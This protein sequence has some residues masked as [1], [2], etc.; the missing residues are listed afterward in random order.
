M[1]NESEGEKEDREEKKLYPSTI[2]KSIQVIL[3]PK[4]FKQG[5]FTG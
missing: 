5:L 2:L 4:G 1:S 3:S